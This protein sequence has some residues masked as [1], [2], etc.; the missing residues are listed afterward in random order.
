MIKCI[1]QFDE[2]KPRQTNRFTEFRVMDN[3]YNVNMLSLYWSFEWLPEEYIIGIIYWEDYTCYSEEV[4]DYYK[5]KT[6]GDT[7][8]IMNW[9]KYKIN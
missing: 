1:K 7:E 9:K 5:Y 4:S 3:V 6:I 2:I 8:E